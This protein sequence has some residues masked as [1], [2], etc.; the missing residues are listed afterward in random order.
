LFKI[1]LKFIQMKKKN[2]YNI[3]RHKFSEEQLE[4][5]IEN[6]RVF[7]QRS[8]GQA[9]K[10]HSSYFVCCQSKRRR[11]HSLF[12]ILCSLK[13]LKTNAYKGSGV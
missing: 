10:V 12:L 3:S 2:H 5:G 7:G 1:Y 13:S 11:W 6:G 4:E 9:S 8:Q